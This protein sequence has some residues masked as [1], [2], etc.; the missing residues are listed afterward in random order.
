MDGTRIVSA[1]GGQATALDRIVRRGSDDEESAWAPLLL[2]AAA[3]H[4][5]TAWRADPQWGDRAV[6][7]DV[8]RERARG[9]ADLVGALRAYPDALRD[10]MPIVIRRPP[11]VNAERRAA[12]G[13]GAGRR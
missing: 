9:V 3:T 5:A 6:A 10:A 12:A 7:A 4:A 8:G 11:D 13:D 1:A 2:P